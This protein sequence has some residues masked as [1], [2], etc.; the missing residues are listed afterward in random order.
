MAARRA[1][2]SSS[3]PVF[4]TAGAKHGASLSERA[5]GGK[6]AAGLA[7][8]AL[9]ALPGGGVRG[10]TAGDELAL[11]EAVQRH[12]HIYLTRPERRESGEGV[13]LD[14][15]GEL[16]I[17]FLRTLPAERREAWLCQGI[18][19]LLVGR[20]AGA[21]GIA[22][23]FRAVPEAQSAALVFYELETAL[24]ADAKGR[25]DQRRHATPR[26]RMRISRER[27]LTLDSAAVARELEPGACLEN[28]ERLLDSI[29]AP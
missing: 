4:P 10:A 6:R 17:R 27:G 1:D 12:L 25:Y 7:L 24:Q 3:S 26:A 15:T 5:T 13:T 28:G 11:M 22:A 21:D 20:L 23:L 8:A 9:L 2:E 19:W 16:E 14:S 18:R 29:L